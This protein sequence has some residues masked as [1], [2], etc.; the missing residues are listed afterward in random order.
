MSSRGTRV[1]VGLTVLVLGAAALAVVRPGD[2][3]PSPNSCTAAGVDPQ[4]A[5]SRELPRG[6]MRLFPDYTVV[7]FYGIPGSSRAGVLG[8]GA[9]SRA[10]RG[11]LR[12]ARSYRRPTRPVMPALEVVA[13]VA[14]GVPGADG[15]YRTCQP[16]RVIRRYL[17]AARRAHALLILDI[18]PGR[19]TFLSEVRRLRSYLEQP[20][21]GVALDP[22][23]NVGSRGIPGRGVGSVDAETVN[24]V[25][26]YLQEIASRRGLPQKILI[27]HQFE[28]RMIRRERRLE[29][30]PRIAVTVDVDGFG[31][32]A[33]KLRKYR[34]LA[35]PHDDIYDGIKLFYRADTNLL[36][37]P[38]VMDLRPRPDLIIYQ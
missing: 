24:Q 8:I 21:V 30:R 26:A 2:N 12:Q 23:W 32:R 34:Y 22:E 18:Q 3:D 11:L 14:Q 33:L 4:S 27:V 35:R 28:D 36:T 13:T 7:A 19:S 9:P 20:D 17:R 25:S 38:E 15:K 31:R 16:E 37:P 29:Q 10:A 6:G 5:P 1:L